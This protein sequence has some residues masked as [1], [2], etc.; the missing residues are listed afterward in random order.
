MP[1]P[2]ILKPGQSYTFNQYFSLPFAPKD[3]L[4]ELGCSLERS[5]LTL[6]RYVDEI[7]LSDLNR[8]LERN[9]NRADLTS[10]TARRETLIAPILLEACDS[11]C[12]MLQ[13][14]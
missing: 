10:E 11:T 13:F 3:I 1:K 2:L 7:N 12:S 9:L 5:P 6:P 8:Q 4:V 14:I